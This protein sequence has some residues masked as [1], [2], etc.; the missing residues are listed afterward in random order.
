MLQGNDN[1]GGGTDAAID[2]LRPLGD[3]FFIVATTSY[4]ETV[5][6]Y[7]LSVFVLGI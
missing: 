2:T 5:G 4:G 3:V 1:G 6:D 7:D